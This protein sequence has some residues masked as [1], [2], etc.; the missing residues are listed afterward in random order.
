MTSTSTYYIIDRDVRCKDVLRFM[1]I[2]MIE[3]CKAIFR[4]ALSLVSM[5]SKK[6]LKVSKYAFGLCLMYVMS[7][8]NTIHDDEGTTSD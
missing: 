4:L 2:F 6:E 7:S 5:V 8:T 1:D 3:G